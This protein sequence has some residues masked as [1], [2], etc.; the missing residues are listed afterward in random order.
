MW[1]GCGERLGLKSP[2][3]WAMWVLAL[4][5]LGAS[6]QADAAPARSGLTEDEA[7][8]ISVFRSAS[9][10]VVY[11]TS[12]AVR[13]DLFSLNAVEVP[14]GS[15][16]GFVWDRQGYVV[17][18]F[19][20][21]S[22]ADRLIITL[23]DQSQW[24]ATVVGAAPEKDLAVLKVGAPPAA[25]RPL[26]LGN[27]EELEVGRK[28]LAIGNPFGLDTTLT[29]G[30]VS[31]LGREIEAVNDRKIRD[32]IQTDA[33]INPGNSGGPLLNSQG[34]LIGVNTA[35]YSPSGGSAGI[36][37]AIPVNT[38]KRYVPQLIRYGRIRRPVLGVEPANE[39]W[40][41]SR[42]IEGIVVAQVQPGS[43]ADRAGMRGAAMGRQGGVIL[44]DVILAIDGR[45]VGSVDD[46]LG[47]LE[48][49]DP[50]ETVVI[51]AQRAQREREYRIRF[52]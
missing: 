40:S 6:A 47:A 21:I 52:D 13:R 28:V 39:R 36:G 3:R 19:H 34:Q 38:V 22:G 15:G 24:P 32:V 14:Q 12:T 30:I 50:G 29:T 2:L 10:A 4:G 1:C 20:V 23:S 42:G 17:T 31:A 27:S 49:V 18:N 45:R 35:I 37:F 8:S 46:M 48:E 9:P 33:A 51:R 25:L 43:P 7:N 11:V 5:C 26:P 16:S 41:R 44:G